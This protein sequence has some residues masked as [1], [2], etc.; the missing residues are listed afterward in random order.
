MYSNI[1]D[2]TTYSLSLLGKYNNICKTASI[3]NDAHI[4]ITSDAV[5]LIHD[6]GFNDI[7]FSLIML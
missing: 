6:W 2:S 5:F 7:V 1:H 4:Y 3:S